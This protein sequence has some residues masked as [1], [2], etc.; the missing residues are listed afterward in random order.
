M[1]T[2]YVIEEV[3]KRESVHGYVQS[4][5][6]ACDGALDPPTP[7]LISSVSLIDWSEQ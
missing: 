6:R 5:D 3:S 7:W 1:E 2:D 4:F